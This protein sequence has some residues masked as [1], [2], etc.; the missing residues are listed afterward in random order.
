MNMITPPS[1]YGGHRVRVMWERPV[2]IWSVWP[3]NRLRKPMPIYVFVGYVQGRDQPQ[4]S[5]KPL[6]ICLPGDG[7]RP[8]VI[9][10]PL[11]YDGGSFRHGPYVKSSLY[12]TENRGYTLSRLFELLHHWA[13][14]GDEN[15]GAAEKQELDQA[16]N[17]FYT[18]IW[19]EQRLD[20]EARA[21][22]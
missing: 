17:H 6:R 21:D 13:E 7:S 16:L 19:R 14:H 20:R 4:G 3:F 8:F 10:D 5:E 2:G 18:W 15:W 9:V 1:G 22:C 11:D 12:D